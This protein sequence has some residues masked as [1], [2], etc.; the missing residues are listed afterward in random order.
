MKQ[1][2]TRKAGVTPILFVP[3]LFLVTALLALAACDNPSGEGGGGGAILSFDAN[4]GEPAPTALTLIAGSKATEPAKPAK[5]GY[6]FDGWYKDA[7]FATAWDFATDTV[8]ADTVLY[9]KWTANP[10]TFTLTFNADG[11]EPAPAAQPLTGS[12]KATKPADPA[13][14]GYAFDGWYK[15]AGFTT[16][17]DFAS[18]TVSANTALYA[19]WTRT[20]TLSFNTKG[21][22]P[23]P[24]AQPLTG[25]SKATK[26]ADPAKDDYAF[27]GWYK[28]AEFATA[29]DFDTDTVSADVTLYAKWNKAPQ[30]VSVSVTFDAATNSLKQS[31]AITLSK[32]A[33]GTAVVEAL[34]GFSSYLWI[35]DDNEVKGTG[36]ALTLNAAALEQ[37]RHRLVLFVTDSSGVPYSSPEI[38]VDVTE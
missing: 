15:D 13:K 1:V 29:W 6:A 9:A 16:A 18:D 24:A 11:G 21:G 37:G 26:P 35:L 4:G 8:S 28:D 5:D 17:W 14:N 25:G 10:E 30:P 32:A 23:I 7:E 20:Y 12:S 31:G 36:E 27:D 3:A 2:S 22:E 38:V 34:G 19:K 33:A